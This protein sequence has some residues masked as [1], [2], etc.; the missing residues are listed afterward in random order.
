MHG[1]SL[2]NMKL[3]IQRPR[4]RFCN[5]LALIAKFD[6][7][8]LGCWE[9]IKGNVAPETGLASFGTSKKQAPELSAGKK[10]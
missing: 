5:S 8:E 4:T 6:R 1:I 3:K 2:R 7:L 10:R 9:E